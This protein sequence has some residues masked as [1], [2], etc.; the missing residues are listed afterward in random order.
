MAPPPLPADYNQNGG[1]G[2]DIGGGG[3]SSNVTAPAPTSG[4]GGGGGGGG[5]KWDDDNWGF[6]PPPPPMSTAAAPPA[7]QQQGWVGSS[8]VP[9]GGPQ[10]PFS[11]PATHNSHQFSSSASKS[12]AAV[13]N[14]VLFLSLSSPF[15]NLHV[16]LFLLPLFCPIVIRNNVFMPSQRRLDVS[17]QGFFTLFNLSKH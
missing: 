3:W 10:D 11:S 7:A 4:G 2:G 14:Q 12:N 9:G 16:N 6:P 13:T 15:N 17:K 8:P 5:S 1:G